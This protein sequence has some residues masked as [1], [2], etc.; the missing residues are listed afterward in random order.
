MLDELRS[1]RLMI[2]FLAEFVSNFKRML[3]FEKMKWHEHE[4]CS[5]SGKKSA[6]NFFRD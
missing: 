2:I 1:V 3:N 5:C 6:P 4:A